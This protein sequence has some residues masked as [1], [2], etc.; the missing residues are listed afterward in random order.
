SLSALSLKPPEAA[1]KPLV[2]EA[3]G[4]PEGY[5]AQLLDQPNGPMVVYEQTRETGVYRLFRNSGREGY[6]VAQPDPRE[7]DLTPC[8]EADRE[9]VSKLLP[10]TYENDPGRMTVTT[11]DSD[12]KQELWGPLLLAVIG[13]LCGEIWMTSRIVKGR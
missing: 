12:P 10:M 5:L 3:S 2:Y 7:S 6:Y 9:K 8:T 13:L 1:I 11:A 4:A